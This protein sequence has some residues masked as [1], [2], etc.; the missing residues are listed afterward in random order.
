[1]KKVVCIITSFITILS[2]TAQEK[3]S[4]FEPSNIIKIAPLNL[5]LN[6]YQLSFESIYKEKRSFEILLNYSYR[7]DLK[8]YDVKKSAFFES[9]DRHEAEILTNYRFYTS[10]KILAGKGFYFGPSVSYT[11]TYTKTR[12]TDYNF[13]TIGLGGITGYQ[14]LF[15]KNKS[16][17]SLD[18]NI[19]PQY[20]FLVN[21]NHHMGDQFFIPLGIK[22]GYRYK[23]SRVN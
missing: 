21:N 18:I 11:Y 13:S 16:L 22:L 10:K 2:I 9:A 17:I 20:R 8:V 6:N 1:M 7:D 5:L 12:M 19:T 14:I 15:G 23:K 4:T 3:I